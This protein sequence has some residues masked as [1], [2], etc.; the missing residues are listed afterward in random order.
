MNRRASWSALAELWLRMTLA[1]YAAL[2]IAAARLA[3]QT[4]DRP[5]VPAT[6]GTLAGIVHDTLGQPLG[7]VEVSIPGTTVAGR[8]DGAGAFTLAQ[9]PTGLHEVWARKIGFIVAQF[10]WTSR[11][12]ERV[13]IAVTL[14][15]LPHTL[16]P[17]VVWASEERA[18]TSTSYVRGV[19]TD[20]AGFPLD[21][22]EVQ[23]IGTGRGTVTAGDG[24]FIFRH[25]KPGVL[26]LR[27]RMMGYSPAA[28][29]MKLMEQDERD[30]V[31]RM[32]NLAQE[33]DEVHVTAES[34]YGRSESAWKDLDRR[35]RFHIEGSARVVGAEQ[36]D[37]MGS[38][39]LDLALRGFAGGFGTAP[40]TIKA[41]NSTPISHGGSGAPG[42]ACILENGVTP[43]SRPLAVYVASDLRLVE[44]YPAASPRGS[45]ETEYTQSVI[46]RMA[47]VPGCSGELGEHPAYYVLWFKGGK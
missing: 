8:S 28:S 46:Y 21:G 38:T 9:V 23:L 27:A 16:D 7:D 4:P 44:Y 32:G 26:T 40:T 15:P 42:D 37:G 47:G 11:A 3:A 35:M 14:R 30:V 1:G 25:V 41:G 31:L 45:P 43:I 20:S 36:L 17:V 19:V 5:R 18:M 33:L 34:G 10:N 39:P 22:V 24:S 29:V 12:D 6:T 13:E 2:T